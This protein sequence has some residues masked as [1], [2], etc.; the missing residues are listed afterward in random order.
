MLFRSSSLTITLSS[1]TDWDIFWTDKQWIRFVYDRVHLDANQRVNHFR[2]YYELCRKD[3]LIKNLKKTKR[4]LA[5]QG[6]SSSCLA[7]SFHPCTGRTAE[8]DSYNFFPATFSLPGEYLLFVEAFKRAPESKWIM[9]PVGRS[10]G[11]G[12]FLFERLSD[13][14]E[15]KADT[16]WGPQVQDPS[17][18][19]ERYIVQQYLSNPL[20]VGG[21]KFDLRM[22]CLVTSYSPLT[23]YM[24]REGFARFTS[25]RYELNS[26]NMDD[27]YVHLTNVA[28]QKQ[29]P[30][31]D[32]ESGGKMELRALKQYLLTRYPASAVDG[33]LAAM[34]DLVIKSLLAVQPVMISDRQ[35]FA[36]LHPQVFGTLFSAL[37]CTATMCS[38]TPISNRGSLR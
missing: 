37:N 31:Y 20:L 8:A 28:V 25:S 27:T 26:A 15:W 38:S 2:N 23:A 3:N 13:I 14:N 36:L 6:P 19:A 24:Y 11:K 21:K 16:R 32:P 12:I 7:S 4:A 35:R 30:D 5:K 33:M 9:K 10:Q 17:Q 22:Y 34:Q 29:G 1:E 18:Q